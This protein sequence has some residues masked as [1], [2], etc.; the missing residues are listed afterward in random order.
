MIHYR[1]LALLT[2][3]LLWSC[4]DYGQL[5][6]IQHLPA[7]MKEVSGMEKFP[8][9]DLIWMIN[10]SG[11]KN[12][13]YGLR[14]GTSSLKTI[15]ITNAEN[16]DWED[17]AR[18]RSGHLYIG[19]FGN[20]RNKREDLVIYK[21]KN[22]EKNTSGKTTASKIFFKLE[23]QKAYPPKKKDRNFDIEAFVHVKDKLYLFT[24]NRSSKSDGISKIYRL[25]DKPGR[26]TAKWIGEFQSCQ[27]NSCRIT[28]ATVSEDQK[29]L[30]LLTHKSVYVVTDYEKDHFPGGKIKRLEFGH[31]S[32]KESLC[33]K[34][35]NSLYIADEQAAATGRNLFKFRLDQ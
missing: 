27:K 10:D 35:S 14:P 8:E 13:L 1:I 15:E 18:D 4:E 3:F 21:I 32:Q 16:K 2:I 28:A 11:N 20:N 23:D 24:K 34:D 30:I 5:K 9:S 31:N 6:K 12:L 7:T 29:K 19:D 33:F 25:P 22:P 17:L 26:H